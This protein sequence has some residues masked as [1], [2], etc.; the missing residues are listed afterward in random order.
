MTLDVNWNEEH[1]GNRWRRAY[2]SPLPTPFFGL[3]T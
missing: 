1:L 3:I 2:N